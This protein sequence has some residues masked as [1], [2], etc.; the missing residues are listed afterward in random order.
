MRCALIL[1][2]AALFLVVAPNPARAVYECGGVKDDCSCGGSNP[3]PCCSNNGNCTWYAWH[4][5]CCHWGKALPPWG[6]ANTWSGYAASHPDYDP[7]GTPTANCVGNRVTPQYPGDQWGH[8]AWVEA[9]GTSVKVT[10]QGCQAWA[11]VQTA[12]FSLGFFDKYIC[13]KGGS[14]P[15]GPS[16]GD[17]ACNGGE[18]CQSCSQDCGQCCGNGACDNGETCQSCQGDCGACCGNGACDYGETCQSCEGDCGPCCGNGACDYGETCQTCEKDC[19]PCCGNGTCDSFIPE[20]CFNCAQDCGKC[21]GNGSCDWGE[22]CDSCAADCGVCVYM[23][24][25]Y[26][27]VANCGEVRGWADD[28]DAAPPVTIEILVDGEVVAEPVADLPTTDHGDCGFDVPW[29][30]VMKDGEAHLVEAQ[31]LDDTGITGLLPGS[32]RWVQCGSGEEVR[33]IWTITRTEAGGVAIDLSPTYDPGSALTLV[34]AG[35]LAWPLSGR[36]EARASL[37][38]DPLDEV[39]F[40]ANGG[41]D[42]ALYQVELLAGA[43]AEPFGA[44][45]D[46]VWVPSET[47]EVGF[48]LST[49]DAAVDPTH[50]FLDVTGLAARTGGWWNAYSW[51]AAG[52]TWEH[53]APDRVAFELRPGGM[54]TRGAASCWHSFAEP[55]DGI[56]FS[57]DQDLVAGLAGQ[58]LVD[59]ELIVQMGAAFLKSTV[60]LEVPGQ[61]LRLRFLSDPGLE[62]PAGT[63]I[64]LDDVRVHRSRTESLF[65][66]QL[67]WTRAWDLRAA[68]PEPDLHGLA[69]HLSAASEDDWYATGILEARTQVAEEPCESCSDVGVAPEEP[70]HEVPAFDRVRG[71]VSWQLDG[72]YSGKL[73]VNEEVIREL[74]AGTGDGE[75][76]ELKTSGWFFATRL[77]VDPE[78]PGVGDAWVE[79]TGLS[80]HRGGWWTTADNATRGLVDGRLEPCG[81]RLMDQPGWAAAGLEAEGQLLVHR[82]FASPVTGVRFHRSGAAPGIVLSLV[83]DGQDAATWVDP[84]GEGDE[85][86]SGTAKEIGFRVILPQPRIFNASWTLALTAIEVKVGGTWL[87]ACSHPESDAWVLECPGESCP[88]DDPPG[89]PAVSGENSGGCGVGAAPVAG[90][91]LLL[92]LLGLA[93]WRPLRPSATDSL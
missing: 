49:L 24:Q 79:V 27:E 23:P 61:E 80:F 14:G 46:R 32:G 55:F 33:G 42:A 19:G 67:T 85:A 31:A 88:P 58:L 34:H 52:F 77:A 57:V 5:A 26:L 8:V 92:L 1:S 78:G 3:Y 21:C 56:S 73:L 71:L 9:V 84:S 63:G 65:P 20:H 16:C 28:P 83:T 15:I 40:H 17:G 86:W 64:R 37:G 11:G 62:V 81:V 25:G 87:S 4:A 29:P 2:V 91:W 13:L 38:P 74:T 12:W 44:E 47:G 6:N 18:S 48:R 45:G 89:T 43:A 30:D 93:A 69:V 53:G 60:D 41:F 7:K 68:L 76:F 36:I 50:R 35:G 70:S 90:W 82:V 75:P 10:H 66:W 72:A 54:A 39:R 22:N 51:D 59:G